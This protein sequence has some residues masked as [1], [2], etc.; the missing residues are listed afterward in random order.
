MADTST[1]GIYHVRE[2]AEVP[3]SSAL[4]AGRLLLGGANGIVYSDDDGTTWERTS[5]YWPFRWWAYDFAFVDD[6]GHRYGGIAYASVKGYHFED[7]AY[8]TVWASEDGGVTWEERA[9]FPFGSFGLDRIDRDAHIIALGDGSLVLGLSREDGGR[10]RDHGVVI[11]SSDGG[12]TWSPLGPPS[13]WP[14]SGPPAGACSG[15]CPDGAWPG[16]N[17]MTF[18]LDAHGRLWVATD[19]GLWRTMG[20]AWAVSGEPV[21]LEAGRLALEVFPNPTSGAVTVEVGL[22]VAARVRVAVY[23][24]Q[25]REVAVMHNG[26]LASGQRLE[27]ETAAWPAGAYVV[28]VE[29]EAGRTASAGLT[30]AR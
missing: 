20:A 27:V 22:E 23:D 17:P 16:W 10:N 1:T 19:T 14:S 24:V 11:H 30:V 3:V 7:D 8:T 26:P 21:D 6:S 5:L 29:D 2:I 4:P 15:G 13:P 9:R 12:R 28:R 25:G 18:Q